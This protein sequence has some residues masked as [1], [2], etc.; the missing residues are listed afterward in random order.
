VENFL[1]DIEFDDAF[2][3]YKANFARGEVIEL[4]ACNYPDAVCEAHMLDAN[5]LS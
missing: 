3:T 1:I 2:S 4:S 5:N